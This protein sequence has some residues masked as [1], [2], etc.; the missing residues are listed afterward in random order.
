MHR[1]PQPQPQGLEEMVGALSAGQAETVAPL[2]SA[3][4]RLLCPRRRCRIFALLILQTL[5]SLPGNL[6]VRCRQREFLF[7]GF[8]ITSPRFSRGQNFSLPWG[9]KG[10]RRK[11]TTCAMEARMVPLFLHLEPP[12]FWQRAKCGGLRAVRR[13]MP[14]AHALVSKTE[15]PCGSLTGWVRVL[16]LL[17]NPCTK[18]WRLTPRQQFCRMALFRDSRSQPVGCALPA[19]EARQSVRR[20]DRPAHEGGLST[21]CLDGVSRDS[22]PCRKETP[23]I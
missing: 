6:R 8:L 9:M 12:L 13:P 16:L 3:N 4:H 17:G 23:L 7:L 20:G 19:C 15:V 18:L 5:L 2:G 21:L 10:M 22:W 14:A 11:L 1:E